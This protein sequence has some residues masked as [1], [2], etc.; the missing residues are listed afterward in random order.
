[1]TLKYKQDKSFWE[2]NSH[3]SKSLE[4]KEDYKIEKTKKDIP[5][6]MENLKDEVK[7]A[8]SYRYDES[9]AED[10]GTAAL[11][12]HIQ[13]E[14]ENHK[15]ELEDAVESNEKFN[16]TLVEEDMEKARKLPRGH[17]AFT[18]KTK[19][20]KI[21]QIQQ[22]GVVKPKKE[23]KEIYSDINPAIKDMSTKNMERTIFEI[24]TDNGMSE[25][26]AETNISNMST[27]D[28]ENYIADSSSEDF[29]VR[30]K[31]ARHTRERSGKFFVAGKMEPLTKRSVIQS[32]NVSQEAFDREF[33]NPKQIN[34]WYRYK[35][36]P[37]HGGFP[38][39]GTESAM[40]IDKQGRKFEAFRNPKVK[41]IYLLR[42][43]Q[44]G[45]AFKTNSNL[46]ADSSSEDFAIRK[47]PVRHQRHLPTGKIVEAGHGA[48]EES[49]EEKKYINESKK[50]VVD[51]TK[52][53][54]GK[55]PDSE[56]PGRDTRGEES[57]L[58]PA[59]EGFK[60]VEIENLEDKIKDMHNRGASIIRIA[61][62]LLGVSILNKEINK[63][64]QTSGNKKYNVKDY[65]K[66]VLDEENRELEKLDSSG[67]PIKNYP[68]DD[69]RID[70]DMNKG[71]PWGAQ[72]R[73]PGKGKGKLGQSEYDKL[74]AKVIKLNDD[75]VVN[76]GRF[77]NAKGKVVKMGGGANGYTVKMNDGTTAWIAAIDVKK[78]DK[79][80]QHKITPKDTPEFKAGYLE[81]KHGENFKGKSIKI[82]EKSTFTFEKSRK[83]GAKDKIKR[84]AKGAKFSKKEKKE[85]NDWNVTDGKRTPSWRKKQS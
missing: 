9:R 23:N 70:R 5:L 28:M 82:L 3:L 60:A 12:D 47:K 49:P 18:R 26:N 65:I 22:K 19:T 54:L 41:N 56:W 38:T 50:R 43:A 69:P 51:A 52:K 78:D 72:K 8:E 77:K 4:F 83:K 48:P 58:T 7:A 42:I 2:K 40:A 39:Q 36:G 17:K 1:M 59:E 81:G 63:I 71:L 76:A 53:F 13:S 37:I 44:K 85:L 10:P 46:F 84:K 62:S 55:D 64:R 66:D 16:E 32:M 79:L 14:E 6:L 25:K 67:A 29:A 80:S 21:A 57:E 20:G 75:V 61:N 34:G 30:K 68:E 11:F 27:K 73:N 35:G 33:S 24:M 45:E 15:Q 31:P 74:N